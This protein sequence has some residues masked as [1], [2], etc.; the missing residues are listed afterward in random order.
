MTFCVECRFWSEETA[1]DNIDGRAICLKLTEETMVGPVKRLCI[2]R[3]RGDHT[4]EFF[5][6][7]TVE[8]LMGKGSA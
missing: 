2:I 5:K 8:Q 1:E 7:M 6:P 3:T 4:C